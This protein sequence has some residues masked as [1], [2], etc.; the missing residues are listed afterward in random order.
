M[1]RALQA[2]AA[3]W[4]AVSLVGLVA[5]LGFVR[6][7]AQAPTTAAT[8]S[9]DQIDVYVQRR[10]RALKVPAAALVVVDDG[11]V[12]HLHGFG[13]VGS[14]G[15]APN[16]ATPFVLASLSKSFTAVAVLQLVEAG[17]ID[18]D[19]PVTQYLPWFTLADAGAA[20]Q[21]TVGELLN[22]TSGLAMWTGLR[23]LTDFDSGPLAAERQAR[24]LARQPLASAPGT[25]WQ[26][27]NTNYNLLGLIVEVASGET[28]PDY[29]QTHIFNP[30]GMQHSYTD[31]TTALR[32][33]LAIGHRY[34]FGYPIATASLAL[35]AGSIASGQ[36]ISSP[37][38]MGHYLIAQLDGGAYEGNRILSP[39]STATLH[40]GAVE[41]TMMGRNSGQYAMGWFV[42]DANGQP[43]Y[44]HNGEAPD[45]A[46]Y[47]ALL[48]DQNRAFALL[49]NSNHMVMNYALDDIGS[50]ITSILAGGQ[51]TAHLGFLPWAIRALL[52]IPLLQLLAAGLTVRRL[53]GWRQDPVTRPAGRRAQILHIWVPILGNALLIVPVVA[54]LWSSTLRVMLLF[55]PD[56]T[57]LALE[58]GGFA[59]VW[60]VV[61]TALVA[62]TLRLPSSPRLPRRRAGAPV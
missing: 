7:D 15:V 5:V 36:L 61:R 14:A 51:A 1:N 37:E 28:Y 43:V 62:R 13:K 16:G 18:L 46:T 30:L 35:P 47:M 24:Q 25:S 42:S 57:W 31:R 32:N 27:N 17:K 40:R 38:D 4:A 2:R 53:I 8:S 33:G 26:Y 11:R 10:L 59:G 6:A 55:M 41:A 44:W 56:V 45:Y 12:V 22:Q 39:A 60:L 21:I 52:L 58:V 19:A 20:R 3:K 23:T 54:M 34:W 49:M 29:I 50:G 9:F 48:P